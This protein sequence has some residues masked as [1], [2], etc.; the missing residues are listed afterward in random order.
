MVS[1][2]SAWKEM[3]ICAAEREKESETE[4]GRERERM[5]S[6]KTV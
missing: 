6:S 3:I 5:K 4:E 2:G 1:E